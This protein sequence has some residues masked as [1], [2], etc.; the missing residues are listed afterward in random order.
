MN[1]LFRQDESAGHGGANA[2]SSRRT[3]AW[4]GTIKRH[5]TGEAV[6]TKHLLVVTSQLSAM[7]SSGCDLCA[8]LEALSR[9]QAHPRL[10]RVLVDLHQRVKQGQSFSSS[11]AQ[12]P[13]VFSDLY[14]TMVRAGESA[15]LLK[16]MLAALQ[17]LIRNNIRIVG[18]IR[19]AL[20]YPVIL[21]SVAVVVIGVMTTFVLPRFTAVFKASHVPLPPTTLFVIATSEFIA[22]HWM[23]LL[24]IVLALAFGVMCL[25][26]HR[27]VKARVHKWVLKSPLLGRTLILAYV[28]RSIQTLGM[29]IK[30]GLPLADALVLTRDMMPNMYYWRF[31]DQLRAHIGEGKSLHADFDTTTLFPPMVSQM[32][33]VGEQTGTLAQVC[34]DSA[35]FHE[36]EL[37]DRIKMLT[38]AMEPLII[39]LLGGFVGFLAIS[40]I[41]P[42]FKLSSAVH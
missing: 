36:E 30:S 19:S 15:G 6:S 21:L 4:L 35:S 14:V 12:H 34:M 3:L 5:L 17:A 1:S 22:A 42:M 2:I 8:A 37:H 40:I 20:I 28:V 29:L 7:L 16:H 38:T 24:A 31:Y 39:V 26:Q 41:L 9:Q 32:V 18:A 10:K 13:D 33:F 25:L 27:E 11:L 23:A